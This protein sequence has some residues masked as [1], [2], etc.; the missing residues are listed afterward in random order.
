MNVTLAAKTFRRLMLCLARKA[1]FLLAVTAMARAAGATNFT[2]E[3]VLA[4]IEIRRSSVV[5]I[6]L[7]YRWWKEYTAFYYKLQD[8]QFAYDV[9]RGVRRADEQ[10]DLATPIS[11]GRY[12]L[13]LRG[14]DVAYKIFDVS[15]G[16][17]QV[18]ERLVFDGEI[19][20]WLK[21]SKKRGLIDRAIPREVIPFAVVAEAL[22][23]GQSTIDQIL[24]IVGTVTEILGDRIED[25]DV[26]IDMKVTVPSNNVKIIGGVLPKPPH[27]EMLVSMNASRSFWP[28]R[29]ET[30]VVIYPPGA[31]SQ[32]LKT[33]EVV[34]DGYL[35]SDGISYPKKVTAKSFQ[36]PPSTVA[37][38]DAE[39]TE[40]L[41]VIEMFNI[42]Q[43][44]VNAA[45]P[46]DE[47]QL[48]FPPETRVLD[49]ANGGQYIVGADGVL[50]DLAEVM[51][52]PIL[53]PED[54]TW[55]EAQEIL[56]EHQQKAA[57]PPVA[58]VRFW[59]LSLNILVVCMLFG[60]FLYRQ[61][62]RARRSDA[63]S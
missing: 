59:L 54:Y 2:V 32:R 45:V 50:K 61:V 21:P 49:K 51:Q 17:P 10:R 4:G 22:G 58:R 52:Q 33:Q 46:D 18:Y 44:A 40:T 11:T 14:D 31:E 55:E 29:I 28:Q 62:A 6:K 39:E 35:E 27:R 24:Q 43:F 1:M 12:E 23:D 3:D 56:R 30:F 60:F 47:F 36:T 26:L 34:V 41:T 16:K 53:S 15:D 38:G 13:A 42:E 19:L 9:K 7:T 25:G 48:E 5:T 20:R 37:S 57:Q 8:D 63:V